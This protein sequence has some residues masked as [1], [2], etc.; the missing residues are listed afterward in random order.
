MSDELKRC[1]FCDEEIRIK[2]LICKH[3]GQWM[4]GYAYESAIRDLVLQNKSPN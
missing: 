1:P 2:A 4:P 3:C